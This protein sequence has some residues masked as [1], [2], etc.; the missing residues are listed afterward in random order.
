M[1]QSEQGHYVLCDFGSATARVLKPEVLGHWTGISTL[2]I[3]ISKGSGV[4]AVDEE[5]K[6]YTT[7]S[8][9]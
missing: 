5:I 9:R 3:S 8:Y 4:Q 2:F 1:L 6:K 7:L